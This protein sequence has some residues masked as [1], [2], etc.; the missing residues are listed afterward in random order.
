MW[1]KRNDWEDEVNFKFYDVMVWLT[2]IT[3]QVLP[4]TSRSKGNHTMQFGYVIGYK[5]RILFLKDNAKND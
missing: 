4:N 5:K 1:T 3:I 2:T